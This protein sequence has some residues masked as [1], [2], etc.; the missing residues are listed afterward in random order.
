M[1]PTLLDE[2]NH[3]GARQ[4]EN[5][6]V[7]D[8]EQHTELGRRHDVVTAV[9]RL[10]VEV[11]TGRRAPTLKLQHNRPKEGEEDDT[12]NLIFSRTTGAI[13]NP[14]VFCNLFPF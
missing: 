8:N 2:G 7:E 5:E 9:V 10:W 1:T 14:M 4:Q 12:E 11:R 3:K 6:E 13:Q